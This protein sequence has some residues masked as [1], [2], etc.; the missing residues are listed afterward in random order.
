MNFENIYIKNELE[1]KE[2]I[3]QIKTEGKDN[4]YIVFDFDNALSKAYVNDKLFMS[5]IAQIRVGNYLTEEYR[6]GAHALYEEYY[7]WEKNV[8]LPFEERSKKMYEWW[9][10]HLDLKIKHGLNK[11]VVEDIVKKDMILLRDKTIELFDLFLTLDLPVLI[12]SAGAGSMIDLT[13]QKNNCNHKNVHILSNFYDFDDNGKCIGY[14]GD[15]IHVLNKNSDGIKNTPI[16]DLIKTRKNVLLVGDSLSDLNMV[17]GLDVNKL[18]IGFYN[19]KDDKLLQ[20]Y[21][22]AF[23]VLIFNDG[24]MDYL[25]ELMNVIFYK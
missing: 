10:R 9:E 1:L 4:F 6:Q 12:F 11:D 8:D 5:T 21:K 14:K 2:K 22:D 16:F 18:N 17:D 24:S 23:D 7:P 25:I 20:K 3:E 13:L 19:F 15:I